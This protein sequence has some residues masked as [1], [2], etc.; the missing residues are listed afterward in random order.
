MEY[1]LFFLV[2][3]S[4]IFALLLYALQTSYFFF[5]ALLKYVHIIYCATNFISPVPGYLFKYQ[6]LTVYPSN[7]LSSRS[8]KLLYSLRC[9][10]ISD[11][12]KWFS[13]LDINRI[14]FILRIQ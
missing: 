4:R 1:I 8:D 13:K 6:V 3:Y 9:C 12:V 2:H 5:I 7:K 14:Q 10:I 11:N